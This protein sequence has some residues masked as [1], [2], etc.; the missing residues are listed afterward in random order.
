MKLN[1]HS[2]LGAAFAL[3]RWRSRQK[4]DGYLLTTMVFIALPPV[5]SFVA[6]PDVGAACLMGLFLIGLAIACARLM[7]SAAKV[8]E[9][10]RNNP[11]LEN[12]AAVA[13]GHVA[14]S[15]PI[16]SKIEYGSGSGLDLT[17][18]EGYLN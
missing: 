4:F 9:I 12:E 5:L 18:V 14:H 13:P 15:D 6:A 3:R 7:F 17:A 10:Q 8:V 16:A 11:P 2:R 1:E